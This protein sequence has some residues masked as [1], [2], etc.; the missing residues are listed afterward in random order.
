[1]SA[2]PT[3]LNANGCVIDPSIGERLIDAAVAAG[4]RRIDLRWRVGITQRRM[5]RRMMRAFA[6][7]DRL[8]IDTEF[9]G[10]EDSGLFLGI[11]YVVD[12]TIRGD[13]IVLEVVKETE[14]I[15]MLYGLGVD[16]WVEDPEPTPED[17]AKL[18]V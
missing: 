14:R 1:M 12:S 18:E 16:Y 4:R 5:I 9:G 11:Q 13:G 3:T 7:L 17:I 15:G 2:A 6:P 8:R 10:G